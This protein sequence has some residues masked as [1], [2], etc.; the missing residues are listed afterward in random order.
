M[1][2]VNVKVLRT[3]GSTER[4]GKIRRATDISLKMGNSLKPL[5]RLLEKGKGRHQSGLGSETNTRQHHSNQTKVMKQ[6]HPGKEPSRWPKLQTN[7]HPLG[8]VGEVVLSE[9]DTLRVPRRA[10]SILQHSHCVWLTGRCIPG[11]PIAAAIETIC[12]QPI[13]STDIRRHSGQHRHLAH[14][15][16]AAQNN[17]R[18]SVGNHS[19][20]PLKTG[21]RSARIGWR[22]RDSNHTCSQTRHIRGDEFETC[23]V[24]Q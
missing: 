11:W 9:H 6:R 24:K 4:I 19:T 8:I 15:V 16:L 23:I 2:K 20:Q 17:T 1:G 3:P 10:R 14:K 18:R 22:Y 21:R 13:Q 5:L 12:C 7:A